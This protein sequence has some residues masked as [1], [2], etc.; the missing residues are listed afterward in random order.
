MNL[1][2][3]LGDHFKKLINI[4]EYATCKRCLDITERP[5]VGWCR[6]RTIWRM[7]SSNKRTFIK[8]YCDAFEE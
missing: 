3:K 5:E 4:I 7:R 8:N 6:V 2:Q 1:I